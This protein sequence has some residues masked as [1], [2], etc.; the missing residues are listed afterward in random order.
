M[1]YLVSIIAFGSPACSAC[2]LHTNG[3]GSTGCTAA[4]ATI[5]LCVNQLYVTYSLF[6]SAHTNRA[7]EGVRRHTMNL[8]TLPEDVF[9]DVAR[10]LEIM[11]ILSLRKVAAHVHLL[12]NVDAHHRRFLTSPT[13]LQGACAISPAHAV[14][15][16]TYCCR[17]SCTGTYQYRVVQFR[18]SP[19]YPLSAWNA[20]LYE[21]YSC[22]ITGL[23]LGRKSRVKPRSRLT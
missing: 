14:S 10:F 16:L 18:R 2:S 15:G 4:G 19:R 17:R 22:A 11:D 1:Y 20:W 7:T 5:A 8:D 13:R 9:L 23:R 21:L 6:H 3:P 12:L